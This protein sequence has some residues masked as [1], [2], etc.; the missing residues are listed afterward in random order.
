MN[1]SDIEMGGLYCYPNHNAAV[2]IFKD[3]V[4]DYLSEY[5]FTIRKGTPFV[6]LELFQPRSMSTRK[7]LYRLKV[8][9]A[10][11]KIGYLVI[12]DSLTHIQPVTT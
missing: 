1:I 12:S 2:A 11:G 3:P 5:V 4:N 8:L 10:T 7:T 9:T 6:P